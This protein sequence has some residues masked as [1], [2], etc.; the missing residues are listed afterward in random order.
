MHTSGDYDGLKQRKRLQ[1]SQGE[2]GLVSLDVNPSD[3]ITLFW[4]F[5]SCQDSP[6]VFMP[7]E[8]KSLGSPAEKE[9]FVCTSNDALT[10]GGDKFNLTIYLMEVK[11]QEAFNPGA[12][13]RISQ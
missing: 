2:D 8:I 13:N 3:V 1:H 9:C 6:L 7:S 10:S 12:N 5:T 11:V 4:P